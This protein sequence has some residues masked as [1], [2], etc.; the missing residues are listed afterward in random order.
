MDYQTLLRAVKAD[1]DHADFTALRMAYVNSDLYTP[2]AFSRQE[3]EALWEAVQQDDMARLAELA[4]QFLEE[5]FMDVECHLLAYIAHENLGNEEKASYHRSCFQGFLNS[6]LSSGDGRT[7]QTAFVV[8]NANEE[9]AL[10]MA[11]GLTPKGQ[12]LI[13]SGDEICDL[14]L[15]E[16]SEG[17][18]GQI[19]FNVTIPHRWLEE[20]ISEEDEGEEA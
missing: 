8:I 2:Y 4:E 13:K 9:Y 18:S 20:H 5:N 3:R 19:F 17:R 1:P 11:L 10:L 14:I 6:I 12:M 7:P 15:V 16:D